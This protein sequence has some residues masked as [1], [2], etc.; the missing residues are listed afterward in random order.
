MN[1]FCGSTM[2]SPSTVTLSES[3]SITVPP[4]T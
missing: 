3:H 4:M 1:S 2:L